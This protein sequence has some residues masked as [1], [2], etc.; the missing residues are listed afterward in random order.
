MGI[1]NYVGHQG[2]RSRAIH[3]A[4]GWGKACDHEFVNM[5]HR[6]RFTPD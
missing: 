4:L 3:R 6:A 2:R 5:H 1:D